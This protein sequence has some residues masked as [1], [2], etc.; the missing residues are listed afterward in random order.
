MIR[1]NIVKYRESK[2][3]VNAYGDNE[4]NVKVEMIKKEF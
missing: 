2:Y 4:V 1:K 3:P